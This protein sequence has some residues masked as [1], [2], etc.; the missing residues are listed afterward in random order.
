LL[1]TYHIKHLYLFVII[2]L[3][4]LSCSG[5]PSEHILFDFESD[6]EL[7]KLKWKC[8][9]LFSLSSE[10]AT[11]GA[12][13][14]KMELFPS[15]YPGFSPKLSEKDWRRHR[16][17]SFDIFNAQ[18]ANVT[19]IMRIDDQ[20]E[21]TGYADR[22]NQ[23]FRLDSGANTVSI[24]LDSLVT[25]GNP[26]RLDLKNIHKLIIFLSHPKQMHVLYLDYLRIN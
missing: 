25:S 16:T 7:D 15:D 10:H 22:Y 18:D 5:K 3:I 26:R 21:N 12:H 2:A 6:S 19:V 24:P 9:T 14:L 11:H 4:L 13:S 20:P 17:L 8:R 23:K 1:K